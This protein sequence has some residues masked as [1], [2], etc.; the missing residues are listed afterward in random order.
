MSMGQAIKSAY[1]WGMGL[2]IQGNLALS[3]AL[4]DYLLTYSLL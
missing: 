3:S 2:G 1:L 4:F